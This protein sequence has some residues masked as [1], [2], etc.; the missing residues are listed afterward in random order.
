MWHSA[1]LGGVW[2]PI[3]ARANLKGTVPFMFE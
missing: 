3:P 1:V 2:R